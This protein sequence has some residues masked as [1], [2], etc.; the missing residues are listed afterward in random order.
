M[1][2]V[3]AAEEKFSINFSK[4]KTKFC[5]SLHYNKGSSYLLINATKSVS[6]EPMKLSYSIWS[7]KHIW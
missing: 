5:L 2:Y 4:R 7:R 6:L 1:L 3:G